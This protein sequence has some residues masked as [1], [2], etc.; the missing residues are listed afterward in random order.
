MVPQFRLPE[1]VIG[2]VDGYWRQILCVE[3]L[4]VMESDSLVWVKP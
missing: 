4:L 1:L 3:I 2:R